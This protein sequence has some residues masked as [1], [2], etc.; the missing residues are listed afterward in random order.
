MVEEQEEELQ[1]DL[2]EEQDNEEISENQVS[3]DDSLQSVESE[4]ISSVYDTEGMYLVV[5]P[6]FLLTVDD[7]SMLPLFY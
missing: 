1:E 7:R 6:N 2:Q 5:F 3:E 4:Q